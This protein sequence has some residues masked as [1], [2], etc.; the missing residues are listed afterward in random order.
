MRAGEDSVTRSD[1]PTALPVSGESQ[2]SP[3][4]WR[5]VDGEGIRCNGGI[6]VPEHIRCGWITRADGEDSFPPDDIDAS[7][8]VRA[9][10]A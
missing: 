8:I 6:F 3:L 4:P 9:C 2:H 10:N 7:Y 5:V 1:S